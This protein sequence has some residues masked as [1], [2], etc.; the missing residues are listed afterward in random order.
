MASERELCRTHSSS[1]LATLLVAV[2]PWSEPWGGQITFSRHLLR[3][4]GR[5]LA[6]ASTCIADLP[7]GIWV[8]R[9][10]ENVSIRYFN[11]GHLAPPNGK[12]P[13][14]PARVSVYWMARR[15]MKTVFETAPRN[16]LLDDPEL[17][18]PACRLPWESVC[19]CFPSVNNPVANSRYTFLRWLGSAFEHRM[20]NA[21]DSIRPSAIIAAAD[22]AAIAG[23]KS[24][25]GPPINTSVIHS[26]PTRVDTTLFYPEPRQAARRTLGLPLDIPV[27]VVVGRLCW[28]KGWSFLLDVLSSLRDSLPAVRLEFVGDGED[29]MALVAKTRALALAD[30]VHITGFVPQ[31]RLRAYINAADLCLVGSFREGWSLAMLEALACGQRIVSTDVSGAAAMIQNGRNGFIVRR[32][33]GRFADAVISAMKLR[34]YAALSL[35]TVRQFSLE[36]LEQDLGA[37]W[38]PLAGRQTS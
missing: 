28:I 2:D 26:F 33:V 29:R 35:E 38:P 27:L 16:I 5:R 22:E 15:Y 7:E 1:P 17:L 14:I 19:Y 34:D 13:L 25:C 30:R 18:F 9:R 23:L 10:F 31:S 12:R 21:L 8:D 6:V 11:L 32:D 4:F 20:M 36:T 3:A 37:I 24:R